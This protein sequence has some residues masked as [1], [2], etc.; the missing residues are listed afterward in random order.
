MT[1][2][3]ATIGPVSSGKNLKTFLEKTDMV[4]LNLSHNKFEW[5]KKIINK[6][7][8]ENKDKL[9]LVDVPGVKP[10]TLNTNVIRI[11]KGEIIKFGFESKGKNIINL[12]N[13]LPKIINKPKT[14]SISDGT[15]EFNFKSI[16]KNVIT[17]V[18][19]QNFDLYPKKGLNIPNSIYDDNLQKKT[20]IKFLNKI[21]QLKIDCVGLSFVQ[22]SNV[23]KY[24]KKKFPNFLYISKLENSLGYKNRKNII[25]QSDAIMIDR[26]D[27]AAEVGVTKFLSYTNDIIHDAKLLA[28]PTIIATE[29]LNSLIAGSAPSKSDVLNI[30]Y[31]L[32]KSVDFIMLSDETAT[33]KNWQNTLDWLRKF[34]SYKVKSK[35]IN[36]NALSI[37]QIVKNLKNETIIIFSKKGFFFNKIDFSNH[38]KIILF[39][40]NIRI[41]KLSKLKTNT[42]SNYIK[43]PKKNLDNFM[44]TNIKKNMRDIFRFS[45]YA[46]LVN[47]RFP[48]KNSRANT[49]SIVEKKDFL[50][51]NE[52]Y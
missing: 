8:E 9:I 32:K 44:Y 46:Y 23:I 34:L 39:T 43:Y 51:T 21:S 25:A 41:C 7:R 19:E 15:F 10:R 35:N 4:R 20:Y 24:L 50:T 28:K 17:G 11:K 37:L 31:Y 26:G 29:N 13:P 1:K 16:K 27:L 3:L 6:I 30:D 40:E 36:I 48:R 42:T 52:K 38:E 33:S 49:L 47:V 18:S 22:N 14:F 2:I 5:H 45:D 12:S